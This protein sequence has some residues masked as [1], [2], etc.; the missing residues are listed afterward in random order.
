MTGKELIIYILQHNLENEEVIDKCGNIAGFMTMDDV[1][2]ECGVD[3]STVKTWVALGALSG[4]R[5]GQ[6][7]YIRKSETNMQVIDKLK[8]LCK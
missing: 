4:F 8:R 3:T 5:I 2:V 1:A 7:L 6:V